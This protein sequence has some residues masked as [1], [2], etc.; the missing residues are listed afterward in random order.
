[1][2][3]ND[4]TDVSSSISEDELLMKDVIG[5]DSDLFYLDSF[6]SEILRKG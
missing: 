4:K 3:E 2:T 5:E 1:M 6:L